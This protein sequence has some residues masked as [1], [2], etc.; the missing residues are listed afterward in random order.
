MPETL[1]VTKSTED[2]FPSYAIESLGDGEVAL[3]PV[4]PGH[5]RL[6][7]GDVV[8][9]SGVPVVE[10]ID[11]RGTAAETAGRWFTDNP[12]N[13]EGYSKGRLM[14]SGGGHTRNRFVDIPEDAAFEH[15]TRN[16][17]NEVMTEANGT[18]GLPEEWLLPKDLADQSTEYQVKEVDQLYEHDIE[19]GLHDLLS[20]PELQEHLSSMN[21]SKANRDDL[22]RDPSMM[23]MIL[24][25]LSMGLSQNHYR[26]SNPEELEAVI[27]DLYRGVQSAHKQRYIGPPP[28]TKLPEVTTVQQDASNQEDE[29]W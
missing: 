26:V 25:Q 3:P 14:Q 17:P 19:L 1:Q 28:E 23:T 22:I 29:V 20:S 10:L 4:A 6:Y 9:D 12:V 13:A 27:T 21:V 18:A 2:S 7:R 5:I 8:D 11:G 24:E 16:L 15:N